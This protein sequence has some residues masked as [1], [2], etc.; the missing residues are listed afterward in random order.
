MLCRAMELGEWQYSHVCYWITRIVC[1]EATKRGWRYPAILYTLPSN[2][3]HWYLMRNSCVSF[4]KQHL[5]G[6]SAWNT[7]KSEEGWKQ[8]TCS[9]HPNAEDLS[10]SI[11]LLSSPRWHMH[12]GKCGF[13]IWNFWSLPAVI[14][15]KTEVRSHIMYWIYLKFWPLNFRN[16]DRVIINDQCGYLMRTKAASLN[17]GGVV[18]GYAFLNSVF[19]TWHG[20]TCETCVSV[21]IWIILQAGYRRIHNLYAITFSRNHTNVISMT[22]FFLFGMISLSAEI[23]VPLFPCIKML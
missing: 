3:L 7:D 14:N 22:H 17:E 10:T 20:K 18:A 16:K 4:R 11:T 13:W 19:L 15:R 9:L 12:S 5:W 21:W 1:S 23:E 8:W 2:Y 6:Q